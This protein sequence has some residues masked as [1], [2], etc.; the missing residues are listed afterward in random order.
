[1]NVLAD[2]CWEHEDLQS[3][4]FT[5]GLMKESNNSQQKILVKKKN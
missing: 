2:T 4:E 1:M 5:V 3:I